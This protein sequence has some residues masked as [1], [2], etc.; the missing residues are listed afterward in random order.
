MILVMDAGNTSISFAVMDGERIL[1]TWAMNT[2]DYITIDMFQQGFAKAEVKPRDIEGGMLA[3]VVPFENHVL[4]EY[5][6]ALSWKNLLVMGDDNVKLNIEIHVD[7]P[8]EV[9]ADRI[10]N[11]VAGAHYF[12]GPLV[13]VDFGTATTFDVV[14]PKGDYLGGAITTGIG[15]SVKALHEYTAKLPLI[16]IEAPAS[17]LVTGKN[18]REAMKSG[19]YFGSL[20]MVEGMIERFRK[21]YGADLT[22]VATGGFSNL[23]AGQTS[24][25]Q[26]HRPDLT[27]Q[28]LRLIYE[29]NTRSNPNG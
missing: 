19:L 16:E 7:N 25:L 6:R 20:S 13:V 15:L 29:Y 10:A 11:A 23:L 4:R 24:S 2:N 3:S 9:G 17:G 1:H 26:H 5:F 28:G 8:K 21:E 27:L 18:T 22:T 14:G 12:G